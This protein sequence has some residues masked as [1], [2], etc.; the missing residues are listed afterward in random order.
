[1]VTMA[2]SGIPNIDEAISIPIFGIAQDV[3][4]G[5][6]QALNLSITT[7]TMIHKRYANYN[8]A[9]DSALVIHEWGHF[10]SAR[11]AW[12]DNNQGSAMGE[13]WSDFLALLAVVKEQDRT[14]TGNEQFQAAY[15]IFQY[16]SPSQ[17]DFYPFGVRRYPYS[18]DFT[19]NPLTFRY[20]SDRVALPTDV[21]VSPDA[22]ITGYHNSEVHNS[23]EIWASMLWEV[24]AALLNDTARL[25]FNEAQNRMLDYLV[26]S[27]KM[28]PT[29][30][31]FLEAR[32]ALLAV[33]NAYDPA[34][35]ALFWQAFAKRGAGIGAIAPPRYSTS[36]AGAVEDFQY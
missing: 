8:S 35:Y 30:P 14:I 4:T 16:V 21:S 19:K 11:L 24:Y 7:A 5:I 20:I 10:L 6:K 3:G 26:A 28:T 32:D 13:G 1:M 22:D 2:G 23:G 27:L 34:D 12:L 9:L 25:S 18:T 31:T 17:P 29:S 36:H 33:A 15:P